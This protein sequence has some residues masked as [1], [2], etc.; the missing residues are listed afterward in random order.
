MLSRERYVLRS[1][2]PATHVALGDMDAALAEL[3][4]VNEL[5]CPWFF[6]CLPIRASNLSTDSPSTPNC[7]RLSW[8]W[9]PPW[10]WNRKW[11]IRTISASLQETSTGKPIKLAKSPPLLVEFFAGCH[12]LSE[13]PAIFM[14]AGIC[15]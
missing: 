14:P 12:S 4:A 11:P 10:R 3:R 1:F 9:K 15:R 8:T 7:R 6:Q 2:T 13:L 5:R